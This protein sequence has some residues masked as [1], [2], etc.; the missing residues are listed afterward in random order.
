MIVQYL[1]VHYWT[2]IVSVDRGDF[3]P[4]AGF[5]TSGPVWMNTAAAAAKLVIW[6]EV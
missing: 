4:S 1:Q 2:K 6:L 3:E 5:S